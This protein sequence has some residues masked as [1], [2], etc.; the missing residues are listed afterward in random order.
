GSRQSSMSSEWTQRRSAPR[1]C[2]GASCA[3]LAVAL[4][5]LLVLAASAPGCGQSKNENR[6]KPI[7]ANLDIQPFTGTPNPGVFLEKKQTT[8]DLVT[9]NVNLH[10]PSPVSFDAFTLEFHYDPTLVQVTDAFEVNSTLLGNCCFNGDPNCDPCQP[11]CQFGAA[12]A[13]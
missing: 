10:A 12:L 9:V 11:L 3:R 1:P 4:S 2:L 13:N 8:G 5:A 6:I 7:A